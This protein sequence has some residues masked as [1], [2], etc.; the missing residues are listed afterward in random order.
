MPL[1]SE[2]GCFVQLIYVSSALACESMQNW[3]NQLSD[4]S[5]H[6]FITLFIPGYLMV[7]L[8]VS[9]C[10]AVGWCLKRFHDVSWCLAVG[11]CLV[12]FHDV[13]RCLVRFHGV[14]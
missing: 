12:R 7:S 9:W 6:A 11:W 2:S 3:Y 4:D 8:H 10:L 1:S 14:L 5:E 13:S